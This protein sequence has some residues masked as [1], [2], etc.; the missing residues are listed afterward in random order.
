MGEVKVVLVSIEADPELRHDHGLLRELPTM[1]KR[2]QLAIGDVVKLLI[3]VGDCTQRV[4]VMVRGKTGGVYEGELLSRVIGKAEFRSTH[5]EAGH[6]VYILDRPPAESWEEL[7]RYKP[8]VP[9]AEARESAVALP[10]GYG[11]G[12]EASVSAVEVVESS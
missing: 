10:S 5:F 9:K 6:V 1:R 7:G 4:W 11:E 3:R 8:P 12:T 2:E